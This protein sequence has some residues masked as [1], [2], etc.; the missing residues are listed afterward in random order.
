MCA[1]EEAAVAG[2]GS[3]EAGLAAARSEFYEGS[4][5]QAICSFHEENGGWLR[6]EKR[7]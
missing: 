7:L 5:G 4:I 1:A 2:G 3:R 6:C